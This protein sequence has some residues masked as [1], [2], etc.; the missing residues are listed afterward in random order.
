MKN[1]KTHT[2]TGLTDQLPAAYQLKR[3]VERQIEA[4]FEGYGY[5]FVSSPLSK[6]DGH[7]LRLCYIEKAFRNHERFRGRQDEFTQA[8]AKLI[9][10]TSPEADAELIALAIQ[11]LLAVELDNF[12]VDISH[13]GFL[14]GVLEELR[15]ILSEKDC[16]NFIKH[17][18]HRNFVDAE[19]IAAKVKQALPAGELL[20]DLPQL[21]GNLDVL[22][23][24]YNMTT[25]E[26]A[27]LTLRHLEKVYDILNDQGLADYVLFDLSMAEQ[28]DYYTGLIFKGY[29]KGT[30][31]T[32]VDGGRYDNLLATF[33]EKN[34]KM[35]AIGFE[36]K[37][38]G[39]LDA[40]NAQD[41]P[42]EHE[43]ADTLVAYAEN[44]RAAA[45]A[46]ADI[47]RK[48]G[49]YLI[50]HL[51]AETLDSVKNYASDHKFKGIIYFA[52]SDEVVLINLE[53][54]QEHEVSVEELKCMI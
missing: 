34:E 49:L 40:V 16:K 42:F 33:N 18:I 11:S 23:H 45:L 17:V 27:Q 24:A 12:R 10:V 30:S 5:A 2:P 25:N 37:I 4:T 28:L 1:L 54:K 50:N 26:K 6:N 36:I 44:A 52:S 39:L 31:S 48:Q 9:G 22:K 53:T 32:V 14:S 7:P 51:K 3:I 15:K 20:S 8:G 29:A 41:T 21:T 13:V 38:E 47:L 46:N 43:F 35:P 19:A